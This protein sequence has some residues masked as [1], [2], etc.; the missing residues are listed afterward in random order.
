M[1]AFVV[2]LG[3]FVSLSSFA[4]NH[5]FEFNAESSVFGRYSFSQSKGRGDNTENDQ[6]GSLYF[7]FARTITTRVQAGLQAQYARTSISNG[8]NE[9]LNALLGA[10]YNF[11]EGD[12]VNSV[13]VSLYAG[14]EWS[15]DYWE[16]LEDEHDEALVG[17]LSLGKRFPVTFIHDFFTYSPEVTLKSSN[18]TTSSSTE[19][20]QE[21]IFKFLQFSVF[22]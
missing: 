13:Y 19:W 7:N 12:F 14:M 20:K 8:K 22:F 1:K 17:K 11:S 16:S 6:Y 4:Q 2:I 5:M 9:S 10:I 3:L 15:H 18:P 21:L